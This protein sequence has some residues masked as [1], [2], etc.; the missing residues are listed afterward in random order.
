[1]AA[2]LIAIIS[3]F[4]YSSVLNASDL[5]SEE[6]LKSVI[7]NAAKEIVK[8]SQPNTSQ[9]PK[10]V[11]QPKAK[12]KQYRRPQKEQRLWVRYKDW[13][14]SSDTLLSGGGDWVTECRIHTGGDGD[15]TISVSQMWGE[16][17]PSIVFS[18]ATA[19]GYPTQ[20]QGQQEVSWKVLVGNKAYNFAG[21]TDTG[22]SESGIPY[23]ENTVNSTYQGGETNRILTA[24]ARGSKV[25]LMDEY[26]G[27]DLY[28]GSLSGFT[29]AYRKMSEWC[30]FSVDKV[31]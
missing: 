28:T 25:L 5:F 23:A 17:E 7:G 29:A 24:F 19:R 22:V 2:F 3:S 26:S 1:M 21:T 30:G 6:L 8:Q 12:V 14:A 20:L 11:Q 27:G 18:E 15:S 31:L 13:V 4:S 9:A 16:P 10:V